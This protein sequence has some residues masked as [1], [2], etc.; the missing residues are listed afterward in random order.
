MINRVQQAT[1]YR[2]LKKAENYTE[3]N[4]PSHKFQH[5]LVFFIKWFFVKRN[6]SGEFKVFVDF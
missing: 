1:F 2:L 4:H 6:F 3:S 5:Y